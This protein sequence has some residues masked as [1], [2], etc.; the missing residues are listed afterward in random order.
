MIHHQAHNSKSNYNYNAYV[1]FNTDYSPHFHS[2]YEFIYLL[3]GNL[4]L[5]V[6]GRP[7]Q[8]RAGDCALVLSNQIHAIHTV[9]YSNMWIGVFSQQFVPHFA[10]KIKDMEGSTSVFRCDDATDAFIRESLI[11]SEGSTMLKKACLYAVC[12]Q[13]LKKIPLEKR[14][15]RND[16]IIADMLDYVERHFKEN[17]TLSDLAAHFGYEYHYL[18]RLLNNGYRINFS[19]T[20]N[21]YRVEYAVTLLENTDK[22]I[23]DIALESGFRSIR[24]FNHIFKSVMGMSPSEMIK[25]DNIT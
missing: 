8:M 19:D 9:G 5:T 24:S 25:K 10:S 3:G 15:S 6:N 14:K 23:T 20:V 1:Y 12:D 13:Y 4:T 17:I 2:N 7:E 22:S 21:R 11:L 18:S 16:Q